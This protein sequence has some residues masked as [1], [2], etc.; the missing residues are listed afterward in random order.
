MEMNGWK[1]VS[2]L[3]DL[4]EDRLGYDYVVEWGDKQVK[5]GKSSGLKVRVRQFQVIEN[6]SAV[7]IG[8]IGYTPFHK[9]YA[10][11]ERKLHEHFKD[12]RV[13]KRNELFWMTF[14][15]FME[16]KP[17]LVYEPYDSAETQYVSKERLK[18][19]TLEWISK[20]VQDK[21]K[22]KDKRP[23]PPELVKTMMGLL[24]KHQSM[25]VLVK[26]LYAAE[27]EMRVQRHMKQKGYRTKTYRIKD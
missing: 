10:R 16:R 17:E 20:D 12:V 22:V 7:R 9:N 24:L 18:A 19:E 11:N 4:P 21:P 23:E 26:A 1:V 27:E 15:E 13:S 8:R 25:A 3:D 5:I 6:Y 2:S 14:E